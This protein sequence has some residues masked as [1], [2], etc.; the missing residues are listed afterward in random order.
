LSSEIL[1]ITIVYCFHEGPQY[2]KNI[3]AGEREQL[4]KI[5]FKNTKL[6]IWTSSVNH[7]GVPPSVY[8]HPQRGKHQKGY[9][10]SELK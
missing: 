1:D 7:S 9:F 4:W 5:S 8:D 3:A 6:G 2:Y 10:S